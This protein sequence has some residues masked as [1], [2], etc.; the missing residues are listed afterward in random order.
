MLLQF[1]VTEN[2]MSDRFNIKV[3]IIHTIVM[4]GETSLENLINMLVKV[5]TRPIIELYI[6]T[7]R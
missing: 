5:W 6:E 1:L 3:G 7:V 2:M 4:E